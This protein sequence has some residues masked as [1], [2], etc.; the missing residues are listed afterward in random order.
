MEE[1]GGLDHIEL[2][3]NHENNAV[4]RAAQELIEKYFSEVGVCGCLQIPPPP[5]GYGSCDSLSLL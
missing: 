4:Y 3:Q 1:L 2:L 5:R